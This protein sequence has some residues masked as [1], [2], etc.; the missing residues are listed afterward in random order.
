MLDGG[1]IF[2][3]PDGDDGLLMA[4]QELSNNHEM[5]AEMATVALRRAQDLSWERAAQ[6]ALEALE[7]VVA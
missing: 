2:I 1:G 6:C 3:E 7:E 4:M 5:R